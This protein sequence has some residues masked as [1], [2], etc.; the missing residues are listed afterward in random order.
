MSMDKSSTN[1]DDPISF[2]RRIRVNIMAIDGTW[3]RECTMVNVSN[4]DTILR[5]EASIEGINLSEFFLV[6][7]STGTAYR[8]CSLTWVNGSEIGATFIKAGRP[9]RP[10]GKQSNMKTD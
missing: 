7:S 6:L 1:F 8:R 9:A 3:F 10:S 2:A 5:I 4:V